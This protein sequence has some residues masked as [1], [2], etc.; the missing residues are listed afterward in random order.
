MQGLFGRFGKKDQTVIA[1]SN[2]NF[3]LQDNYG[4]PDNPIEFDEFPV[5]NRFDDEEETNW[6]DIESLGDPNPVVYPQPVIPTP[7]VT[8][9][10]PPDLDD[11]DDALPAATVKSSNTQ[12]ARRSKNPVP[13]NQDRWD[14]DLPTTPPVKDRADGNSSNSVPERAIGFWTSILQQFR[15]ILPPQIRQLSDAILTGIVV[16][17]VTILI[18]VIDT[19]LAIPTEPQLISTTPVADSSIDTPPQISPEQTFIDAIQTQLTDLTHEY[20]NDLI[21]ALQVDL[22]RDLA[23]VKLNLGWYSLTD[24][25]QDRIADRMWLQAQANHLSKLELQTA[26]GDSLARAPVVGKH[27]IILARRQ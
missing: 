23:I 6:D 19:T 1:P 5:T 22:P 7:A 17:I 26:A 10:P 2:S 27:M 20:P 24:L 16:A 12:E 8:I 14:A 11:W 25:E 13:V 15:R 21:N 9:N 18:W 4:D 3:P